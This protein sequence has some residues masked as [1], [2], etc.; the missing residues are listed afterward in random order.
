M[1]EGSSREK[2]VP[3]QASRAEDE[4]DQNLGQGAQ[5]SM[6]STAGL[7]AVRRRPTAGSQEWSGVLAE[8]KG[9]A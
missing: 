4:K 1:L 9:R 7:Y 2:M 8:E 5:R 3:A 6:R